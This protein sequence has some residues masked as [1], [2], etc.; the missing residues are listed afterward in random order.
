M[1]TLRQAG[2]REE[3]LNT[4]RAGL[5][6]L[7]DPSVQRRRP[8]ESTALV[9]LTIGAEEL[10]RDLGGTGA[11]EQDLA[12]TLAMLRGMSAAIERFPDLAAREPAAAKEQRLTW[13]PYL[14]RRLETP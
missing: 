13:I 8:V 14:Q 9:S 5:V 2:R 10:A 3:A 7:R 12:D 11:S 6:L 4:A 1:D